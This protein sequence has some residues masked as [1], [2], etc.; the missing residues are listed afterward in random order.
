MIGALYRRLRGTARRFVKPARLAFN[1]WLAL[2][3]DAEIERL[4][5]ARDSAVKYEQRQHL[6]KVQLAMHRNHISKG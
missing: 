4:R 1:S 6:R 3:T 2:R 5:D